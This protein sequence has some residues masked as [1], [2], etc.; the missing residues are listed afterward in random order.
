VYLFVER[1]GRA[2]VPL[3]VLRAAAW[4]GVALLLLDPGCTR[5]GAPATTVLLDGSRSMTGAADSAR[6]RAAVDSAKA[7]A[8][9]RGRI[10]LFGDDLPRTWTDDARPAAASSRLLPALRAAAAAGGPV[11]VVTD[12]EVDDVGAIPTDLLASAR[13]VL[14]PRPAAADAGV[15][16]IAVP[17]DLRAGDTATAAVDLAVAGASAGDTTVLELLE[18]GRVTARLRVPLGAG[19]SLRR[20]L[21]FV[22]AAA[23]AST[24]RRYEARL[25]QWPRDAE[26]RNDRL[27]TVAA[28][29]PTSAIVVVS[30]QPDYDGRAFAAALVQTSGA[31]VRS[32]VRVG[33]TGWR[34][35]RTLAAVSEDAVRSEVARATLVVAH[36]TPATVQAMG[37]RSRGA[38]LRWPVFGGGRD[39]DWYVAGGD[40]ASPIGAALAGV[41]VESLPPLDLQRDL[42]PDSTG[43]VGVTARRDR[44]GGAAAV[45]VGGEQGGRRVVE[46]GVS[47]LWRW[48]SKGGVAAEGYRALMAAA[49]DWLL[50]GGTPA[51]AALA[52]ERE[53]LA[54]GAAELLPRAPALRAQAGSAARATE[55]RLPLRHS[56]WVYAAVIAALVLEWVAR[57]RLGLR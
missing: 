32:F 38:L 54:R 9:T 2:G 48:S 3:A 8:G 42:G 37:Q 19:G 18:Q 31:P 30:D 46:I 45:L 14:L 10:L 40:A 51:R 11:A 28:V 43:W 44:R 26:P 15:A 47:G 22:P 1:P 35:A 52:A 50:A 20:E 21:R 17:A 29:A 57:R 49:T 6:W 53:A 7:L 41:P 56:L 12:G 24:V 39:G 4:G 33:A 23:A 55:A 27:A 36:G 16:A 13:V 34:D 5:A 25:S